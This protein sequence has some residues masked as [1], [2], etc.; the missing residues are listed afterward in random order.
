[1]AFVRFF[2]E[3]PAPP[4]VGPPILEIYKK[5]IM[6]I[7]LTA[8]TIIASKASVPA[9]SG[10]RLKFSMSGKRPP[11]AQANAGK[12][13]ETPQSPARKL[14]RRD[15]LKWLLGG[16]LA[17]A[18]IGDE[19][20]D[21]RKIQDL[22]VRLSRLEN[23]DASQNQKLRTLENADILQARKLE[24]AE[25]SGTQQAYRLTQLEASTITPNII[26]DA[27]R[28]T[29]SIMGPDGNGAGIFISGDGY[30]LTKAHVAAPESA[31]KKM[32]LSRKQAA[33][34]YTILPFAPWPGD[35][36]GNS[37]HYTAE[38][39]KLKNGQWAWDPV[40][41]LAL[42]KITDK[43]RRIAH[44]IPPDRFRDTRKDPFSPGEPVVLVGQPLDYEDTVTA[45]KI[46]H[47]LRLNTIEEPYPSAQM[48]FQLDAA[49][50]PGNSGGGVF[51]RQG[52]LAGIQDSKEEDGD[53]LCFASRPDIILGWLR[54]SG[55]PEALEGKTP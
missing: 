40:Q 13:P 5:N 48:L 15:A 14:S 10:S 12:K 23:A 9:S 16:T 30:I 19:I 25:T 20:L 3:C 55:L 53:G 38:L 50:N 37:K 34:R 11:D 33:A 22:E 21:N 24:Q 51:D 7:R 29:V 35:S 1:M 45:G 18:L 42:L 36:T 44:Y 39:V 41:D 31:M 32:R 49:C 26:K 4:N 47:Y 43:N 6:P 28:T 2:S 27:V 17:A 46:S 8:A 52:R 54:D